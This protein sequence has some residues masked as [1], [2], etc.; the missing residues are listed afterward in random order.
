[1]IQTAVVILNWNGLSYLTQFLETVVEYSEDPNTEV[2][3]IDNASTDKSIEYIQDNH[4]SVKIITLEK[5]YGFAG[6]YNRGLRQISAEYYI[7]LNS[8]I[9]VT[10]AWTKPLV[11][12]LQSKQIAACMPKIKSYSNKNM[13][14]YAG[15]AGGYI[16]IFGYPFCRGRLFHYIEEDKG[17]YNT[18]CEIFWASG[19]AL[20]I[21]SKHFHEMEGFDDD[22]FAHME[23]IDLC[24]RLKN[25]GYS[26]KYIPES[27]IYH[28]G[29][30][31]LPKENPFK[32]YLNFRNNLFLLYKNILYTNHK[33]I[34]R[35]R[36]FLDYLAIC[37]YFF[38][39]DIK[40]AKAIRDAHKDF[41]KAI[42]SLQEKRKKNNRF[43]NRK[44]HTEII[45][46]S[47]LFQKYILRKKKI[48][49]P[50]Q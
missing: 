35:I 22:F 38:K 13:F 11:K 17:Q 49:I 50:N 3:I 18:E 2:W 48:T 31:T 33:R 21:S 9:E 41:Y 29:G 27:T 39:G 10:Q 47:I 25:A 26:I 24:W 44:K 46:T 36:I 40:N 4:S 28:V 14:E 6:G 16:D 19:A 7:L 20:C 42:P 45:N 37:M 12:A 23:E 34:I 1:M 30:G 32:T 43:S 8:D 15:A 5:N